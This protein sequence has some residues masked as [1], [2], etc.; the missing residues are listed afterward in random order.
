MYNNPFLAAPPAPPLQGCDLLVALT[1]M[2]MP[3]DIR[4]AEE[5]PDL[6]LILGGHDH[7]Y[8]QRQVS[9]FFTR[10]A[11]TQTHT[12][13][14]THTHTHSKSAVGSCVTCNIRSPVYTTL[15]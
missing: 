14:H 13:T 8:E 7:H 10:L 9:F 12:Q 11:H 1:H 5:V 3:N 2:R 15:K 4:L 6:H